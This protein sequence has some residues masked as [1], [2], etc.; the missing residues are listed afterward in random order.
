MPPIDLEKYSG[1]QTPIVERFLDV[2]LLE[3]Y[4]IESKQARHHL[5]LGMPEAR[6][7]NKRN[8]ATSFRLTERKKRKTSSRGPFAAVKS[9]PRSSH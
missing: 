6:A 4:V 1:S 7:I 3:K 2:T 9:P 8:Q 5:G